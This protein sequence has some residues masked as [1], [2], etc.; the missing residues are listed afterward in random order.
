[1]A[2]SSQIG[3]GNTVV[4]FNFLF[5]KIFNQVSDEI[6]GAFNY[7]DP[8]QFGLAKPNRL[9]RAAPLR[10]IDGYWSYKS[11][12]ID[13]P[14]SIYPRA[15]LSNN[16]FIGTSTPEYEYI[17]YTHDIYVNI[18]YNSNGVAI[19]EGPITLFADP[20]WKVTWMN[21]TQSNFKNFNV[22]NIAQQTYSDAIYYRIGLANTFIGTGTNPKN[23]IF[24]GTFQPTGNLSL[25]VPF[26]V[27]FGTSSGVQVYINNNSQPLIDT[28]SVLSSDYT[29]ATG[30]LS[31]SQR[32]NPVFFKVLFF[33]L[34][35]AVIDINW[36]VG[37]G[38]TLIGIGTGAQ[39]VSPAPHSLNSGAP[40]DNITFLNVSKTLDDATSVNF[41]YPPGDSF[42]IRSS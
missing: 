35:T 22:F 25:A 13:K 21:R 23:A 27:G 24:E 4:N 6:Y 33:S 18:G 32:S 5:N 28:F 10:Q 34:S 29:V 41:G 39:I 14:V 3:F 9:R 16:T 42:V 8:S 17:G 40:I 37:F 20:K 31:T 38:N 26:S 36:N 15:S 19:E 11:K 7:D 12:T 1:M 30:L 2:T